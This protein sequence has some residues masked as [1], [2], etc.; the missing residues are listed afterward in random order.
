MVSTKVR[1]ELAN[2]EVVE[3]DQAIAEMS[4]TIADMLEN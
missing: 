4:V 3:V 1:I 2:N